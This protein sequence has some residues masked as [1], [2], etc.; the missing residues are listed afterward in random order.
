MAIE[1]KQIGSGEILLANMGANSIDSDQYVDGSIDGIHLSSNAKDEVLDSKHIIIG[2]KGNGAFT[3]GG[4][5]DS[6][7]T[8]DDIVFSSSRSSKEGG[9]SSTDGVVVDVVNNI[10]QLR[11][12]AT[13]DPIRNV[14]SNNVVYGRI[15]SSAT[16][17]A[18]THT[19]DGTTTVLSDDTSGLTTG[20]YVRQS[21]TEPAFKILSITPNTSFVID[22][23]KSLTIPTG[24]GLEDVSFTISYHHISLG[25]ETIHVFGSATDLNIRFPESTSLLDIRFTDTKL[26]EDTGFGDG[27]FVG[28]ET[29]Q[30]ELTSEVITGTDTT[31]ADTLSRTPV[32]ASSVKLYLNGIL[33][34][35]GV[36]KDYISSG[37][38]ILW[39]A[40]TGT[41]VDMDADDV[42]V[43]DYLS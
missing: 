29:V 24:S 25:I 38:N 15:T 34:T 30:E 36:G 19:W 39:L 40:N 41:A 14:T 42:I 43:V 12:D 2:I 27:A 10:V 9:D 3:A 4:L 17:I 21:S 23:S 7:N 33:Q 20:D 16:P 11:D 5:S 35:Q 32:S 22:N 26:S 8:I 6:N 1:G 28:F 37:T 18:G 13:K 31:L